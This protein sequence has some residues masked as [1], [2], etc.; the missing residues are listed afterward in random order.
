[1]AST[2][3]VAALP[4][5]TTLGFNQEAGELTRARR[6]LVLETRQTATSG[7]VDRYSPP[8]PARDSEQRGVSHDPHPRHDDPGNDGHAKAL[9][10][11]VPGAGGGS[12]RTTRHIPVDRTAGR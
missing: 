5:R 7:R 9:A 4:H 3:S 8:S 6:G 1:M 2:P 11:R 10:R 12:C